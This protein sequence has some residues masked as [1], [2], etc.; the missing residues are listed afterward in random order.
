M[1]LPPDDLGPIIRVGED[2]RLEAIQRLVDADGR[3]DPDHAR[4]FLDSSASMGISLDDLFA[5]LDDGNRIVA[6]VL[7]VRS[8]GRTA[9][10]F[11]SHVRT[12]AE[13]P[14]L[15]GVIR[16]TG[17][18]LD[19][20]DISLS[21]A[22]LDPSEIRERS[23]F[24]QGGFHDLASLSYLERPIPNR[25]QRPRIDWPDNVV[26]VPYEQSRHAEIIPLLNATYHDTLDCP[27]LFG[28]RETADILDGHVAT[29]EFDPTLWTLLEVDEQL[30]GVLM[31]NPS[32]S[33]QSVELVYMGLAP[34]ARGRG[35]GTRLLRHGLSLVSGRRER[36]VTLAVDDLNAPALHV[37]RREGF[38]RFLRR[39]ALI[40]SDQRELSTEH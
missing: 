3:G 22:L 39:R 19:E 16:H 14:S 37:Y 1:P 25:R 36:T 10:L 18:V 40:R 30:A 29:G 32:T 11:A 13:I 7:S 34:I 17:A 8:P 6:S 33:S 31:L 2:R 24:L 4:R 27:G 38:R 28:L 23:A 9:M 35:L 21:Q 15:A 20:T 5:R 12:P 26:A